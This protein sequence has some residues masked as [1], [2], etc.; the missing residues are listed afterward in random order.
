[1]PEGIDLRELWR[2][3]NYHSLAGLGGR[4]A[5]GR[6][7]TAGHSIVYLAE[8]AAGALL[9]VLVH[10]DLED[11]ELPTSYNLMRVVVAGDIEIEQLQS[12]ADSSWRH[13]W[14][15][16]QWI[17]DEWLRSARTALAEVPSAIM[18]KTRNYLL[19]PEHPEAERTQIAEVIPADFDLRLIRKARP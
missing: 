3:S 2:V 12:P 11:A 5:G 1:M 6:W 13:N 4:L 7:H 17:G 15:T 8:S 14:K 9:E 19:N 18:P 16:T 10:L